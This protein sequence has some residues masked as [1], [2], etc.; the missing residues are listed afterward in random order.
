MR[1]TNTF[2]LEKWANEDLIAQKT[3]D[4]F[5]IP[6]DIKSGTYVL[7]TELLAL[8]GNSFSSQ[9][10]GGGGPQFYTHCFNV[11]ITNGGDVTPAN[12]VKFPGGYK[13]EDPGVAFNLRNTAAWDGYVCYY[14]CSP[15]ACWLT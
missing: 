4:T 6:S 11:E 13:R 15:Q 5:Q 12:T 7:R 3:A 1:F 9:P 2:F 8:H 10:V 14:N